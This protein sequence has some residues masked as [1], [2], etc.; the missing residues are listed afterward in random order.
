MLDDADINEGDNASWGYNFCGPVERPLGI[1]VDTRLMS[2][3]SQIDSSGFGQP[4]IAGSVA[5]S[6]GGLGS[7]SGD[8]MCTGDCLKRGE[9]NDR[10][11]E[12]GV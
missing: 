7:A 11:D 5:R 10:G 2:T 9:G 1:A 4:A 8:S 6:G 12:R 3:A